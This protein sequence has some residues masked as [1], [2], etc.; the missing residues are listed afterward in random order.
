MARWM[1]YGGYDRFELAIIDHQLYS[2]MLCV[3]SSYW[4]DLGPEIER[5]EIRLYQ[6]MLFPRR[7]PQVASFV[8]I[9]LQPGS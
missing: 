4:K 7:A 6:M 1:D 2:Q 8:Q 3:A 9:I 5:P